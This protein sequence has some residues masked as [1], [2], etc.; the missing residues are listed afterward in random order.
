MQ[1]AEDIATRA[2]FATDH[3]VKIVETLVGELRKQ[4]L[5]LPSADTLER[6]ALKGRAR[7][8]REAAAA[9][10]DALSPDQRVQLQ[11][12]LVNDPSVGQKP[13]QRLQFRIRSGKCEPRVC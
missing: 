5:V 2:A 10:F 4:H 13:R 9:L 11:V 6:L 1:Q 8:R 7:A 3:G 12:L